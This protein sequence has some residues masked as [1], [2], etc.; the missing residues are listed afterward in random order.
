M[1]ASEAVG[2]LSLLLALVFVTSIGTKILAVRRGELQLLLSVIPGPASFRALVLLMLLAAESCA[3]AALILMPRVGLSISAGLFVLYTGYMATIPDRVPCHC[4]GGS[5][6]FGSRKF[7]RVARNAAL[8]AMCVGGL[9]AVERYGVSTLRL[10]A[11]G[12][13]GVVML[14]AVSIDML[15]RVSKEL[16]ERRSSLPELRDVLGRH[17]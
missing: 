17:S 1:T 13:A 12:A 6:E 16:S 9:V 8:L 3:A 11:L 15:F 5:F 7:P 10:T 14:L 2:G 4:F